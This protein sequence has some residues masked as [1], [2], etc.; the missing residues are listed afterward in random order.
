MSE[1]SRDKSLKK[2]N[3]VGPT[4]YQQIDS[5]NASGRYQLDKNPGVKSCVFPKTIR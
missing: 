5:L 2:T 3:P 4:D 1:L